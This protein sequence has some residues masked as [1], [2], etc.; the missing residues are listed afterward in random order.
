MTERIDDEAVYLE[1]E[2]IC[3]AKN[4]NSDAM[5]RLI[6]RHYPLIQGLSKRICFGMVARDAL[7][8]AGILGLIEAVKRYQSGT[9]VRLIKYEVPWILG[10]MKKALR[11]EVLPSADFYLEQTREEKSDLLLEHVAG[12]EGID[13][14]HIDL[15]L[16]FEKLC[17]EERRL[18]LLRYYEGKT[19]RETAETM[20]KSQSQISRIENRAL[21]M[22][23]IMLG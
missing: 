21:D 10:E 1:A 8:Q 13:M 6:E 23:R 4:G 11:H 7:V 5:R 22:L 12:D 18:I 16:A 15:H 19:Q 3:Q 17:V 9:E 14:R 2:L 20:H